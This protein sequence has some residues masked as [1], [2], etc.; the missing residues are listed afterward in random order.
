MLGEGLQ[1]LTF[2]RASSYP[3]LHSRCVRTYYF[4]VFW[5]NYLP[6]LVVVVGIHGL[7]V[8]RDFHTE[9]EIPTIG[10]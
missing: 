5:I 6:Y 9:T 7:G 4:C 1:G 10:R 3:F 2:L 8:I